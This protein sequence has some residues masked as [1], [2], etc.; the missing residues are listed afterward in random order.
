M[1]KDFC[2]FSTFV[3]SLLGNQQIKHFD[4]KGIEDSSVGRVRTCVSSAFSLL[5]PGLAR[6]VKQM[7]APRKP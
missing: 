7:Q 1:T 2:C 6:C 4:I 3:F 5:R